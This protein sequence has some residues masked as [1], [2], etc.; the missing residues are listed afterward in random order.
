VGCG[1]DLIASGV[2]GEV[3]P[4]GSAPDLAEAIVKL[5]PLT[6]LEETRRRCREKASG[7]TV[8]NAAEG[9]AHAFAKVAPDPK[10]VIQCA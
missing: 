4:N 10:P 5:L 8:E 6:N 2:T 7:Y 3:F 1:P 9:I